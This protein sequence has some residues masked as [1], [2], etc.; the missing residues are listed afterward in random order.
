MQT[1]T[2]YLACLQLNVPVLVSLPLSIS[3]E[4]MLFSFAICTHMQHAL[5]SAP[6]TLLQ[7]AMI[8]R[9]AL[10]ISS[11]SL[12]RPVDLVVCAMQL[13]DKGYQARRARQLDRP[14]PVGRRALVSRWQQPCGE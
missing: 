2:S 9:Q 13:L 6:V 14:H 12:L 8:D 1:V 10:V 5:H 4:F 11:V 3:P 7:F